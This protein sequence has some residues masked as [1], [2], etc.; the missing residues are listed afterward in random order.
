MSDQ[1]DTIELVPGAVYEICLPIEKSKEIAFS[2]SSTHIVEFNV[3]YHQGTEIR[4]PIE[5]T[6]TK[7]KTES[8]PI[9]IAIDHCL[10]WKNQQNKKTTLRY[11]YEIN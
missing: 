1:F 5:K 4:F 10:T 9:E 6:A 7:S 8:V 11:F 2:F 3:H